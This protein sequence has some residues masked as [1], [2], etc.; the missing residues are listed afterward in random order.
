MVS[1]ATFNSTGSISMQ[2][3]LYKVM[4]YFLYFKLK[5]EFLCRRL[6]EGH[7][8]LA[9]FYLEEQAGCGGAHL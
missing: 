2:M 1:R 6:W 4:S 5:I 7:S 9:G 8:S 3:V